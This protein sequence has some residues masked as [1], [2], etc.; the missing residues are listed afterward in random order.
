MSDS[1]TTLRLK[2]TPTARK[3]NIFVSLTVT[4]AE[5]VDIKSDND[6]LSATEVSCRHAF[7]VKQLFIPRT[8]GKFVLIHFAGFLIRR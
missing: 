6:M 5:S 2:L 3:S 1:P 7:G 8:S 4:D